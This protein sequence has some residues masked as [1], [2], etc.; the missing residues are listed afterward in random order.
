[1]AQDRGF[2]REHGLDV[3]LVFMSGTLTDQSVITGETPIGHGTN[4]I[5]TRLAGADLVGILG[6]I[7]RMTFTVFTRP[8]ISGAADLRGK[9]VVTTRPGAAASTATLLALQHLGLEPTRDV[10]LQPSGGTVEKLALM[11]QGLADAS[12]FSTP[13]DLKAAQA[14]LV[15]LLSL[16]ELPIPF[17]QTVVGTT[18]T[19]ARDHAEE[20]RRFVRGYVAAVA[21]ARADATATKAIVGKYIQNDDAEMLDHAYRYYRELWARPDFRVQP[22][23]VQANLRLMDAPGAD[24]ARPEDFIDNRFV[25]ELHAAG[26]IRQVGA[27]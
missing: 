20:V 6:V 7:Q 16:A 17:M 12:L 27:E 19:Y 14:G 2:F 15:P 21:S 9:T 13:D 8:G 23:A 1:V 24:T 10:N 5:P 26:F 18:Q 11:T 3:E 4:L 22:E 25:D